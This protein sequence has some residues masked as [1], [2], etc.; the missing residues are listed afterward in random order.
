M[1]L[2][3]CIQTFFNQG[4]LSKIHS[5]TGG[6]LQPY[7]ELVSNSYLWNCYEWSLS[8]N[9]NVAIIF[10]LQLH[11]N[12]KNAHGTYGWFGSIG[13]EAQSIKYRLDSN[14]C[15]LYSMSSEWIQLYN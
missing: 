8:V 4:C 2:V 3:Q 10:C 11:V 7:L 13:L 14:D 12:D 6:T 1:S 15:A 5:T 9:Y